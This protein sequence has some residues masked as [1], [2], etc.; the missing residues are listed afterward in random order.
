[1]AFQL[2]I[3]IT[4]TYANIRRIQWSSDPQEF[5]AAYNLY[6]YVFINSSVFIRATMM[7]DQP[8]REPTS[9]RAGEPAGLVGPQARPA[10]SAGVTG[11][12]RPGRAPGARAGGCFCLSTEL[13]VLKHMRMHALHDDI[14]TFLTRSSSGPGIRNSPSTEN[15]S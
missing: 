4:E 3:L 1:M 7:S 10:S 6:V 15:P 12:A 8:A 13:C 11:A 14:P 5:W 9:P 2:L